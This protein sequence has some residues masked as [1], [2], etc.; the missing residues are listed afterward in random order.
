M[1]P[2]FVKKS[3]KTHQNTKFLPIIND[4]NMKLIAVHVAENFGP[5]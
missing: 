3:Y 5:F 2:D 4:R 1:V